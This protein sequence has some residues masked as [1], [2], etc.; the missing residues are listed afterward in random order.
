[1]LINHEFKIE[2]PIIMTF[3]LLFERL[4]EFLNTVS[5]NHGLGIYTRVSLAAR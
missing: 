2:L 3:L 1:M 4:K 5:S